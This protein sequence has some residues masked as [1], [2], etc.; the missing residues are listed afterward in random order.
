MKYICDPHIVPSV[1]PADLA[2]IDSY[3]KRIAFARAL[4]VDIVDGRFAENTTWPYTG[5]TAND[6]ETLAATVLSLPE[7]AFGVHLMTQSPVELAE[8]C[9]RAGFV[10]AA[11][12]IES[13]EDADAASE[14]FSRLRASGARELGVALKI[15]TPL[16]ALAGVRGFDIIHLMSIREIGQQGA[17][18]DE[19]ILFRAEETHAEYPDTIVAV[20]G[21]V[22]EASVEEL[23]R[24]GANRLI[25]GHRIAESEN[26]ER[27]YNDIWERAMR[28][29]APLA[30]HDSTVRA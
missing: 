28:G 19:R 8:K 9:I 6:W 1:V 23:V 21:G 4:H 30:Q 12:H 17:Q 29:C 25:V 13:F 16:S 20:D 24:A 14:A 7:I 22:S 26:P 15:D 11:L 27:T 2:S 10:S 18:F 5:I 3:A